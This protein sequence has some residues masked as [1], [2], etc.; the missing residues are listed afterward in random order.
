MRHGGVDLVQA[1]P[2]VVQRVGLH[3]PQPLAAREAAAELVEEDLP[4]YADADAEPREA[5][6]AARLAG[7]RAPRRASCQRNAPTQIPIDLM[8]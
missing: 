1:R 7:P 3:H 6:E 5:P 4:V 8:L 2:R